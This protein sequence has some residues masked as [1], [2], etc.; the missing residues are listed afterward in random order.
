MLDPTK[1]DHAAM[2]N[3]IRALALN[4][5]EAANSDHPGAPMDPINLDGRALIHDIR[6]IYDNY[7][8]ETKTLA[9]SIRTP[10]HITQAALV[11]VDVATSH[12]RAVGFVLGYQRPR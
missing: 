3:C 2:A 7:N 6:T 12:W 5:V 8:F 10:K 9:A 4:A 11:G 1:A